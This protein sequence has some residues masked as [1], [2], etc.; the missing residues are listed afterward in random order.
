VAPEVSVP[1]SERLDG[2]RSRIRFFPDGGASGG[3]VVLQ[4]TG[5]SATVHV[6]WLTGDVRLRMRP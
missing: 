2:V 6:D 4:D 3:R 1:E 5:G